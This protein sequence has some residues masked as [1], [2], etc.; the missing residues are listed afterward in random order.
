MLL[1][2]KKLNAKTARG[3]GEGGGVQ[4]TSQLNAHELLEGVPPNCPWLCRL[5]S[6]VKLI[7]EHSRCTLDLQQA[8]IWM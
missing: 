5:R 1:R 4:G 2:I 7:D 6:T 8:C 3:E